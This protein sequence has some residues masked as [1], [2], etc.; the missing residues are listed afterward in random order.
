L[1][2]LDKKNKLTDVCCNKLIRHFIY[3]L[4]PGRIDVILKTGD[5]PTVNR[6]W[7]VERCPC[8]GYDYFH[9]R[10]HNT[11]IHAK[12][13]KKMYANMEALGQFWGS[14]RTMLQKNQQAT[15]REAIGESPV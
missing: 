7:D 8:M 14:I 11:E 5:G 10:H 9:N 4:S 1:T 2:H 3:G 12:V 6:L 15:I 13:H